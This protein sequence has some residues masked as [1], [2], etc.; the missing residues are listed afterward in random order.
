MRFKVG[1]SELLAFHSAVF[2]KADKD[3]IPVDAAAYRIAEDIRDHR[4]LEGLR[5]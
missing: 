5:Q 4:Q 1:I 2:E 3:R